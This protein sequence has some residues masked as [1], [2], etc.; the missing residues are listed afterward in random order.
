[1]FSDFGSRL[2]TANPQQ[3]ATDQQPTAESGGAQVEVGA[4]TVTKPPGSSKNT[5]SKSRIERTASGAP[6]NKAGMLFTVSEYVLY[7]S[8]KDR[9]GRKRKAKPCTVPDKRE[10][11]FKIK[12]RGVRRIFLQKTKPPSY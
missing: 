8:I 12:N 1:M 5:R 7:A 11:K 4:A 6:W 3:E 2:Q 9:A 10:S